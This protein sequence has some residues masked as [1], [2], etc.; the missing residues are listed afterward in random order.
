MK[1]GLL[2]AVLCW[3]VAEASRTLIDR[4]GASGDSAPRECCNQRRRGKAI[5]CPSIALKQRAALPLPT[6][7]YNLH[8]NQS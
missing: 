2:N 3:R 1:S 5:N 7:P 4:A 6:T 8:F